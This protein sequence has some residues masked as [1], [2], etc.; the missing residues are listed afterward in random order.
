V[1]Y[2]AQSWILLNNKE[3]HHAIRKESAEKMCGPTYENGYWRKTKQ[4]IY[5]GFKSPHALIKERRWKW[6]GLIIRMCCAR[7]TKKFLEDKP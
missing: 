7:T 1:S 4:R 2:G 5:K 3:K 6:T